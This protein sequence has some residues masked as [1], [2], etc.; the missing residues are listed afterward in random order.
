MIEAMACGTPVA[1]LNKGAVPEIVQ[2]GLNGYFTETLDELVEM[3]PQVMALP[4][5]PIRRYVEEHFSVEA[6][7]DS[8]EALY[9]RL[10]AEREAREAHIFQGGELVRTEHAFSSLCAS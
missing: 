2:P 8:Y 3:L 6:M 1:A 5:A 10:V 4:R 7:T 9:Y